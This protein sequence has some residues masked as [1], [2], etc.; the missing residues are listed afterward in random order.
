MATAMFAKTMENLQP[1]MQPIP[2]PGV[3]HH[4]C[5]LSLLLSHMIM[6]N[7]MVFSLW[8]KA[9]GSGSIYIYVDM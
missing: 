7:V 6:P 4:P 1:L 8:N 5:S 2:Q 9:Y 3:L